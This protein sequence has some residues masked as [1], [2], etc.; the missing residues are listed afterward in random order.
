MHQGDN[1][2]EK[3][4]YH[5]NLVD[6]VTQWQVVCCVEGISERFLIPALEKALSL[7]PFE[8]VN[9]HS[10]NGSEYINYTVA[11]LLEK[12]RIAQTKRKS[13]TV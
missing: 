11:T 5:I 6:E 4:V 8:I 12:M 13:E 10:D 9:F 3:G 7:F 2:N 1:G